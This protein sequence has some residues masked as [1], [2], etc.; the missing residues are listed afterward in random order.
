[1]DSRLKR[2]DRY[3]NIK[4]RRRYFP[5]KRRRPKEILFYIVAFT[6]TFTSH[7]TTIM[8]I[9]QYALFVRVAG[10]Q[11]IQRIK[12]SYRRVIIVQS[13]ILLPFVLHGE[14]PHWFRTVVFT[15][16]LYTWRRGTEIPKGRKCDFHVQKYCIFVLKF[17]SL[18]VI[19]CFNILTDN[20]EC[21]QYCVRLLRG[22][23]GVG[24]GV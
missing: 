17:L 23:G 21:D 12:Q 18:K 11:I 3:I 5:R 14:K 19:N 15:C 4:E 9:N 16:T 6:T 1:M 13:L 24:Y 20:T 8:A 7:V 2:I 22:R 10:V